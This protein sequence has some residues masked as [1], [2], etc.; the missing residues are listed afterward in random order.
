MR[1]P[2]V[3]RLNIAPALGFALGRRSGKGSDRK[4]VAM[5]VHRDSLIR[6][7]PP[8]TFCIQKREMVGSRTKKRTYTNLRRPSYQ[9]DPII[10]YRKKMHGT[11]VLYN[12]NMCSL[13]GNGRPNCVYCIG[14][15]GLGLEGIQCTNAGSR[16]LAREET[17]GPGGWSIDLSADRSCGCRDHYECRR[18]VWGERDGV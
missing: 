5:A 12:D 10:L 13:P 18:R 9:T 17:P 15:Q 16:A 6:S 1:D 14:V 7:R 3:N 2:S 11:A 8:C 4:K